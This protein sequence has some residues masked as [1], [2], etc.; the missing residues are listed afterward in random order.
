[1]S[2][3]DFRSTLGSRALARTK[4]PGVRADRTD[5]RKRRKRRVFVTATPSP[6]PC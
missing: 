4:G 5:A 6:A 3:L 1:L 2:E